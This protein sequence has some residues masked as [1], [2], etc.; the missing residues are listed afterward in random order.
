MWKQV[1]NPLLALPSRYACYSRVTSHDI[2]LACRQI[3]DTRENVEASG[4][5]APRP[6]VSLRVLLARD[7][8]RYPPCLQTKNASTYHSISFPLQHINVSSPRL[9]LQ[10]MIY[11]IVCRA[12]LTSVVMEFFFVW[13]WDC[14]WLRNL[15][16]WFVM[17]H[18][19]IWTKQ[20]N[21]HNFTTNYHQTHSIGHNFLR[22]GSFLFMQTSWLNITLSITTAL[23]KEAPSPNSIL[24][25]LNALGRAFLLKT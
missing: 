19:T 10:F 25:H 23:G 18:N 9:K 16:P 20:N 5:S 1:A 22:K 7:F 2:P 24:L 17:S 15:S 4:K 3:S 13:P 12:L 21:S 8:S 14:L 6:S 11:V